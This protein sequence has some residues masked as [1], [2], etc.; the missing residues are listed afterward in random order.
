MTATQEYQKLLTILKEWL[1]HSPKRNVYSKATKQQFL[2]YSYAAGF[3]ICLIV[4]VLHIS[5]VTAYKWLRERPAAHDQ[6]KRL[7]K[8]NRP[9]LKESLNS[10]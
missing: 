2:H 7:R 10:K 6:S 3:K 5:E 8:T 4:K 1:N 9:K